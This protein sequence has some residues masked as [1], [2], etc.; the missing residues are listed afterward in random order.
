M[1]EFTQII[2]LK[3]WNL[4]LCHFTD[5]LITSSSGSLSIF[6]TTKE[7]GETHSYCKFLLIFISSKRKICGV[8][9][10]FKSSVMFLTKSLLLFIWFLSSSSL[11]L[12]I[13]GE[14]LMT[15]LLNNDTML[16]SDHL[17]M[18]CMDFHQSLYKFYTFIYLF[19]TYLANRPLLHTQSKFGIIIAFDV[20]SLYVPSHI[21]DTSSY[22][23]STRKSHSPSAQHICKTCTVLFI[24]LNNV[25]S[26]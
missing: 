12:M 26:E 11:L 21:V 1:D 5:F 7:T 13:S 4:D 14:T 10:K 18:F 9:D 25:N 23:F 15:V 6:A 2:H 24:H 3:F 8:Q 16:W 17:S 19:L 22:M 20:V